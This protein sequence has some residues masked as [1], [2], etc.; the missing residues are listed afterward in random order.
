MANVMQTTMLWSGGKKGMKSRDMSNC[1]RAEL[2]QTIEQLNE[3]LGQCHSMIDGAPV[4][5]WMTDANCKSH[6]FN[7][8][9]IKFTGMKQHSQLDGKT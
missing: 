4:I 6:Y 2:L 3:Q 1:S 8:Q 7:R 9:W 5:L